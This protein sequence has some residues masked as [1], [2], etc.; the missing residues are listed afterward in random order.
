MTFTAG[1]A[2][3]E[4]SLEEKLQHVKDMGFQLVAIAKGKDVVIEG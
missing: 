2:T 4:W 1:V 3:A